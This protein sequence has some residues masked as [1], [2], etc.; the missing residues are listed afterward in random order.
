MLLV[1]PLQVSW[2]AVA[3]YC[4]HENESTTQHF[5]HHE[6]QHAATEADDESNDSS[7][8][9]AHADCVTCH[10]GAVGLT[11]MPFKSQLHVLS[12]LANADDVYLRKS[13]LLPRPERPKW[14]LA[15]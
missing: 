8:I 6:H 5:G 11:M 14:S 4:Q 1:M 13:T 7:P 3:V 12:A 10:G 9:K 2:A 15:V